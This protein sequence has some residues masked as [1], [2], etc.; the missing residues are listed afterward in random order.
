MVNRPFTPQ[1]LISRKIELEQICQLFNQDN[2]FLLVGV[3]GIG[4]RTLIRAAA[5]QVGAKRIEID[6]LRCRNGAQFLQFLADGLTET[7]ATPAELDLIQRWSVDHPLSLDR[8]LSPEARLVWPNEPG[9][10]WQ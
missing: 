5:H 9:K 8:S 1:E 6:C 2:D 4:R 10:E 3:P 7:F